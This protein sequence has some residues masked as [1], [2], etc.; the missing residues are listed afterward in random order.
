LCSTNFT[1]RREAVLTALRWLQR[2]N[3]AYEHITIAEGNL[4][5]MEGKAEAELPCNMEDDLDD[6]MEVE[7]DLGLAPSQVADVAGRPE[8][9]MGMMPKSF[10]HLPK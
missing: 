8:T 7:E 4:S 1:V 9:V 6:E 3:K 2:Y 10:E 5:W